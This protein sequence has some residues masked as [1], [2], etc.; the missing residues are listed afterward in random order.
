MS[1]N[2]NEINELENELELEEEQ[3]K[4][5][6]K[7]LYLLAGVLIIFGVGGLGWGGHKLLSGPTLTEE[8]RAEQ[9]YDE[10]LVAINKEKVKEKLE[11]VKGKPH[12]DAAQK[13][14][15][16]KTSANKKQANLK[17]T[18]D[19][20]VA[21]IEKET[22]EKKQLT[23]ALNEVNKISDTDEEGL[24]TWKENGTEYN[25]LV[26]FKDKYTTEWN[27]FITAV[28]NKEAEINNKK[29]SN[30]EK[31]LTDNEKYDKLEE[32]M[33]NA[34][35]EDKEK[36]TE[37]EADNEYYDEAHKEIDFNKTADKKKEV[38][39]KQVFS[40]KKASFNLIKGQPKTIATPQKQEGN[41]EIKVTPETPKNI[42]ST[43]TT[44]TQDN[45]SKD[46]KGSG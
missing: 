46:K 5:D 13:V 42:S 29:N 15:D 1:E 2:E 44:S 43:P 37:W 22:K 32:K 10:L 45:T 26:G 3:E 31:T 20:R 11:W 41:E 35:E 9:Y 12:F 40:I 25:K 39:L 36:F 17:T 30:V 21:A 27:N 28:N 33:S 23:D 8:Q 14:D 19:E 6:N 24:K 18:A 7:L 34:T 38:N 4:K 16:D